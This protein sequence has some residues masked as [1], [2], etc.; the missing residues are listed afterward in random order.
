MH[1]SSTK[2]KSINLAAK[3]PWLS[4]WTLSSML[5]A[6]KKKCR[7]QPSWKFSDASV[8]PCRKAHK[9][10]L[11][12]AAQ[13]NTSACAVCAHLFQLRAFLAPSSLSDL[14]TRWTQT[15]CQ[16][17]SDHRLEQVLLKAEEAEVAAAV[18]EVVEEVDLVDE[19]EVDV[20]VDVEVVVALLLTLLRIPLRMLSAV[21]TLPPTR[22]PLLPAPALQHTNPR[23]SLLAPMPP[24]TSP[25]TS[26]RISLVR[27]TTDS[28]QPS[29]SLPCLPFK[30]LRCPLLSR[31]GTCLLKP[32]PVRVRRLLSSSFDSEAL[33]FAQATPAVGDFCSRPLAYA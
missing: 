9:K 12:Y 11:S 6:G 8:P 26:S 19:D 20:V 25:R 3:E 7:L 27:S 4:Y 1:N 14:F 17:D 28:F 2:D 24:S 5:P 16:T 29:H 23:L 22:R 18:A 13:S 10:R 30:L 32:R 33:R 21:W 15:A 31:I